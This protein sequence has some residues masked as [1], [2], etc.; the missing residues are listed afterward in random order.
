M[1]DRGHIKRRP[2]YKKLSF[3]EQLL[4]RVKE[5]HNDAPFAVTSKGVDIRGNPTS[6]PWVLSAREALESLG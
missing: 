1:R 5:M 2:C 6:K 3:T 4:P